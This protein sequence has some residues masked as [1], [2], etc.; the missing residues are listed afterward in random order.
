MGFIKDC[1]RLEGY[2]SLM[3]QVLSQYNSHKEDRD[4][5]GLLEKVTK[6]LV[7]IVGNI[8]QDAENL[9]LIETKGRCKRFKRSLEMTLKIFPGG[10]LKKLTSEEIASEIGGI[11]ESLQNELWER[12]FVF[13]PPEKVEFFEKDG[14]EALF[15]DKVYQNF[16]SARVE[17]KDAGNCLAADLNTAAIF[18]LMRVAEIGLRVLA[19]RLKV[20]VKKGQ[21]EY[22]EWK[23]IIDQIEKKIKENVAKLPS[24][25]KKKASAL[26]FYH[27]AIGEFYAF[28]DVWRNNVMHT[29]ESYAEK[30]AVP[31]FNHV[32]GFMQRLAAKISE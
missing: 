1:E 7:N 29:R 19:R 9:Q 27:G 17:V 24:K 28:K 12:R 14:D 20:P 8:K 4:A 18:H 21:L 11:Q 23:N 13:I 16:K 3:P 5:L 10:T 30:E 25:T 32:R 15:G 2:K 6:D 22:L 26:E 31:V